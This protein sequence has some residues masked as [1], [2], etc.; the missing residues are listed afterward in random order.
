[1]YPEGFTVLEDADI[2]EQNFVLLR[3]ETGTS[4]LKGLLIT[5]EIYKF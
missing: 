5:L 2:R 4:V 1:M 3:G